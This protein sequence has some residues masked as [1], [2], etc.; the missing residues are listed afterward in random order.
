MVRREEGYGGEAL[1]TGFIMVS[2]CLV[3]LPFNQIGTFEFLFLLVL[4]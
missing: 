3:T 2:E 4:H 1:G